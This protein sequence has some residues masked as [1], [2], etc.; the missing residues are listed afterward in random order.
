MSAFE[1]KLDPRERAALSVETPLLQFI[2]ETLKY[3][4][5]MPTSLAEFPL[6]NPLGFSCASAGVVTTTAALSSPRRELLATQGASPVSSFFLTSPN[7][8]MAVC[9]FLLAPQ[10]TEGTRYVACHTL[11]E[12]AMPTLAG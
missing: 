4:I 3:R 7:M 12:V 1:I 9:D 2:I 11:A 6:V 5:Q 8:T 10:T